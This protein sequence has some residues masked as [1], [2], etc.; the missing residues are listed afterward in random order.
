MNT[1]AEVAL[2]ADS[3]SDTFTAPVTND[4]LNKVEN[5]TGVNLQV[6][7][8]ASMNSRYSLLPL[9][10]PQEKLSCQEPKSCV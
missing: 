10:V 2:G 9:H 5:A 6:N 1:P 3:I 8:T 7:V 4:T